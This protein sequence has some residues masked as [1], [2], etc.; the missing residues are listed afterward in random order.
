MILLGMSQCLPC[1]KFVKLSEC[2]NWILALNFFLLPNDFA[3]FLNKLQFRSKSRQIIAI[4]LN[5]SN[6]DSAIW[7]SENRK[8]P[9]LREVNGPCHVSGIFLPLRAIYEVK[10]PL[11]KWKKSLLQRNPA[12]MKWHITHLSLVTCYTQNCQ[13]IVLYCD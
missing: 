9:H 6:V 4:V 12:Q 13:N 8:I 11:R 10:I 2:G 1:L 7:E 3:D 5:R